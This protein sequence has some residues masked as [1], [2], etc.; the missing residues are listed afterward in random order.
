MSDEITRL[1]KAQ[2][3]LLKTIASELAKLNA[4][5]APLSPGYRR[6]LS[7]YKS[8]DWSSIGAEVVAQ[9]AQGVS[10]V[11]W[12]GHRFDRRSGEKFG[13]RFI[14]FSRPGGG[15][16]EQRTYYTLIRF[17]DYNT[18]PLANN[19]PKPRRPNGDSAPPG[20]ATPGHQ[21]PPAAASLPVGGTEGGNNDS[22]TAFWTLAG[23]LVQAGKCTHDDAGAIANQAGSWAEKAA[24]LIQEYGP[25][26]V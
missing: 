19:Q 20:L 10:E 8:F 26:P 16:N 14:I 18:T 15:E 13:G 2:I 22:P 4:G 9:D 24:R 5:Q 23:Q 3:G 7:E 11:E 6:R 12:N 17:A 21:P 1:L 25:L